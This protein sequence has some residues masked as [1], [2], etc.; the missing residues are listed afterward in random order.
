MK[1]QGLPVGQL[2]QRVC[3]Y[4]FPVFSSSLWLVLQFHKAADHIYIYIYKYFSMLA[5]VSGSAR[6]LRDAKVNYGAVE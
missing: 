4:I 1:T 5:G 6:R 2:Q 3:K